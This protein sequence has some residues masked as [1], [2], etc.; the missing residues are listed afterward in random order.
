[1]DLGSIISARKAAHALK[2]RLATR[3][4]RMSETSSLGSP[5][6]NLLPAAV[7]S[8]RQALGS[9]P[10][11]TPS[12]VSADELGQEVDELLQLQSPAGPHTTGRRS[13]TQHAKPQMTGRA[14]IEGSEAE[15]P[16]TPKAQQRQQKEGATTEGGEAWER[17]EREWAAEFEEE[18]RRRREEEAAVRAKVCELERTM[19]DRMVCP[20]PTLPPIR[21]HPPS[22][23]YAQA[24]A[25]S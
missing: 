17:R 3:I 20:P 25:Q 9:P 16:F 22:P 6:P 8:S 15:A 10:S 11:R 5:E 21:F 18:A 14:S 1:M 24:Q 23:S 12:A 2:K 4:R 13:R 7:E 19:R